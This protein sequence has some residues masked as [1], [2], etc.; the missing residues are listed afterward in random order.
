MDKKNL[1]SVIVPAFGEDRTIIQDI[2]S[3]EAVLKSIRY[4]Y[5]IV[6]V[7]DGLVSPSD[8]TFE[9]A[10]RLKSNKIQVFGYD[11][12]KGKGY[13]VRYGIARSKGEVVAF[14][15][16]GMELSPNSLSMALEHLEWYN[17]DVIIGSK[18]HPASHVAYP[19]TRRILSLGYQFLVWALFGLKV[20]DTQVGLKIFRREVL[21]K[22]LPRL[23]VKR[24]AFDVEIL[25]VA[26]ALGFKRIYEAPVFFQYNFDYLVNSASFRSIWY[27]FLDTLAVF[28]RLNFLRYYSIRNR[29]N[30]LVDQEV[31]FPPS[32]TNDAQFRILSRF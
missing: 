5:E 13:A 10:S 27:M 11:V 1:L 7:V 16:S 28:Y 18:R 23:L 12:N 25:A 22:V 30:W 26:H 2:L 6:V 15:D 4:D 24:Y 9:Y 20:R 8:R 19:I 14:I 3:L 32:P 31:T 29:R 21:E 17:A